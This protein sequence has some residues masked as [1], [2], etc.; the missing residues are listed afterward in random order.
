VWCDLSRVTQLDLPAWG[1]SVY[2]KVN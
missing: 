2:E 1:Y